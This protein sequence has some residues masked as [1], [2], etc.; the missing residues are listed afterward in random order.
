MRKVLYLVL[1]ILVAGISGC[2]NKEKS[3]T[4]A[5]MPESGC[6]K[7][8]SN[9]GMTTQTT[10]YPCQTA[11]MIRLERIMPTQIN[12][13]QEF[14]YDIIAT[15]LTDTQINE[16]TITEKLGDNFQ[17]KSASPESNFENRQ[18]MWTINELGPN[19]SQKFTV[20]G[21][22]ANAGKIAQC[23]DVKYKMPACG[24]IN[25]VSPHLSL[26][27]VVPSESLLCDRIP[28]K[29]TV[30]N[31][32][33]GVARNVVITDK[34]PD[35]LLTVD[36]G[37]LVALDSCPLGPGQS[38]E[39]SVMVRADKPGQYASTAMAKADGNLTAES[40]G[41]PIMVREPSLVVTEKAPDREYINRPISYNIT[42][43]NN[44]DAPAAK[45]VL[46][47]QLP[48]NATFVSATE[49]GNFSAGT[50]T[51]DL[52]T[53]PSQSSK[54]VQLVY[55]SSSEGVMQT[56]TQAVAE[57]AATAKST[58]QTQIAG[59]PAIL[60]EMWDV[61]DPIQVGEEE[62]YDIQI[63][64]QGSTT[65]S[66]IKV[67]AHLEDTMQYVSSSGPTPGTL[68]GK[69]VVFQP[70]AT[71]APKAVATWTVKVKALAPADARFGVDLTSDQLTRPV[72]KTEATTFYK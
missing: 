31:T 47:K 52:G 70:L 13:G 48:S 64:N 20:T 67:I 14:S 42:V 43:T 11:N 37:N 50:V 27:K 39:F 60:L 34:L 16:V 26:T 54:T 38:Q 40:E 30:T 53:I 24:A 71:L 21:T 69:D 72:T 62:T 68:E 3:E 29:Y 41:T 36:G 63:T 55:S 19:A 49:N 51:W 4:A 59:I 58:A 17:F 2:C 46:Q 65:N 6:P 35:G 33:T 57:C 44:G 61:S 45:T 1:V 15:N 9:E 8:E 28:I 10:V 7:V 66:N 25:V 5:V 23:T 22:A 32:G 56:S 18:L 12:A